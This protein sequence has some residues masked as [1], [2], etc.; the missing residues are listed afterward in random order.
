MDFPDLIM[1]T[2]LKKEKLEINFRSAIRDTQ[3][4][5]KCLKFDECLRYQR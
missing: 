2:D 4:H 3:V 1:E 5:P